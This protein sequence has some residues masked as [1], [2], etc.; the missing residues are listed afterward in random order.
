[1]DTADELREQI[2]ATL[3]RFIADVVLFNHT[4]SVREGLNSSDSQFLTLLQVH[5]P[6]TPGQLAA[7]TGF[8]TGATTGVIDRLERA[9][10]AQRTRDEH[11]R[12]KVIVAPRPDVINA[13][14]A[15]HYGGQARR[16]ADV[17]S[18]RSADELRSIAGFL[19][20]LMADPDP[21]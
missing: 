17:L 11:D 6:T 12:R 16:L 10:F 18:T 13:R 21:T 4:V 15:P 7:M 1:M 14:L 2:Q 5:G 9:G 20:D 19:S 3:I 8:T